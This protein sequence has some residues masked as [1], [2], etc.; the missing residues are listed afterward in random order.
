MEV[1]PMATMEFA[2]YLRC[3]EVEALVL[4]IVGCAVSLALSAL[5]LMVVMRY[6]RSRE[7]GPARVARHS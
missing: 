3:F 5:W 6:L 4:L 1:E 7:H 2:Q